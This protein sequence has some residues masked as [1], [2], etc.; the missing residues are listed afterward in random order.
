LARYSVLKIIFHKVRLSFHNFKTIKT[1]EPK[2][3]KQTLVPQQCIH[4]DHIWVQ[5]SIHVHFTG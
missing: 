5:L 1:I 3:S 2:S 4:L